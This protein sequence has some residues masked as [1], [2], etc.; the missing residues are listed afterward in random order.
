[1]SP[2]T[3]YRPSHCPIRASV[4]L[5]PFFHHPIVPFVSLSTVP[6]VPFV[7]PVGVFLACSIVPQSF[8]FHLLAS[9]LSR[10]PCHLA[11]KIME[12]TPVP[13][14]NP[15]PRPCISGYRGRLGASFRTLR[16]GAWKRHV[17]RIRRVQ[18]FQRVDIREVI[19]LCGRGKKRT[20]ESVREHRRSARGG[21]SPGRWISDDER[22]EGTDGPMAGRV[23]EQEQEDSAAWN[24]VISATKRAV[25]LV[26]ARWHVSAPSSGWRVIRSS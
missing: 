9:H 24:P 7:P 8:S 6:P 22:R 23:T 13:K 15:S 26:G 18:C 25:H 4:L 10:Y 14:E 16:S 3:S 19:S 2:L 21:D 11:P 17:A 5:V 1:M 12:Q 20:K